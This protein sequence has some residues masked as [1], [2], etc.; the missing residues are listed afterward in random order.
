MLDGRSSGGMLAGNGSEENCI[1]FSLLI[2][3]CTISKKIVLLRLYDFLSKTRLRTHRF[4]A[5]LHSI[6]LLPG[7][8]SRP[9]L[10]LWSITAAKAT[11]AWMRCGIH[12]HCIAA[13]LIAE[14]RIHR[15]AQRSSA[16][17]P[18]DKLRHGS[19]FEAIF[20]AYATPQKW[21]KCPS[22]IDVQRTNF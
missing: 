3:A 15:R 12:R 10:K 5:F 2:R 4:V 17:E 6:L 20:S 1:L 16:A 11:R 18:S 14:E 8:S 21:N 19:W 7:S 22:V 9:T 13:S